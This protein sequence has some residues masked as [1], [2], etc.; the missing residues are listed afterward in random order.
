MKEQLPAFESARVLVAGDVM[1]DRYWHG[2]TSRVS[3]EAPVPVVNVNEIEERAG[4]AGNVALNVS[5]LGCQVGLLGVVGK[6]EAADSLRHL[7]KM[8]NVDCHFQVAPDY[9]TVTKLRVISQQQQLIRLDFEQEQGLVDHSS[10]YD[11]YQLEL[12]RVGSVILSDY[13]KGS[14]E[15]C[16]ELISMARYAQLP[17][18]V[19]PKGTD[20]SRYAGATLITPNRKEFEAVVGAVATDDELIEKAYSLI[21][22]YDIYAILVTR[23][24]EG[25]SLICRD[26]EPLH[27][28]AEFREVY[29]VTGAGDTVIAVAAAALAAGT[30]LAAAIEL[31]NT[32]AGITVGKL[33]AA[34]ATVPELRRALH[35]YD[36]FNERIMSE[37]V[38]LQVAEDA[39]AH[40]ETVVMTNGCFDVLHA[41]HIAY[42]EEAKRL[43]DRLIVAVNDDDSVRRLKGDDRP[44]NCLQQRMQVLAGLSAVDWVVPF[45]EDTPQ[46]LISKVLPDILAKGGDYTVDE[47]VGGKEVIANGGDVR[48]LQF[49]EGISTTDTI[50][51]IK[52]LSQ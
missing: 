10:F 41:G 33:G 14:L 24:A 39:Y 28:A 51:R 49:V 31:A 4:G 5:S 46:R 13:G 35:S 43:G 23:G 22:Q 44:V 20:F 30:E 11:T 19:D 8:K 6:D 27:I 52:E 50:D 16:R 48:I 3:P 18:L 25:M 17:V 47:V 34:S 40:N 42:L 26:Q 12:D 36:D 37:E 1:L 2:V 9:P 7:L 45:C 21:E 29:D 32:A 15:D 38:L